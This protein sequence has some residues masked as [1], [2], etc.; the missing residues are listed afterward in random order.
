[1]EHIEASE[2]NERFEEILLRVESGESIV[3]VRNGE[4]IAR[5][6]PCEPRDLQGAADAVSRVRARRKGKPTLST[7]EIRSMISKGRER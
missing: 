2:A 1:M 4:P 3:L 6:I 7:E 5:F